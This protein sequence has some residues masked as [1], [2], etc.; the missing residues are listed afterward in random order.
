LLEKTGNGSKSQVYTARRKSDKT[1][2]AVKVQKYVTLL[3]F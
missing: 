1:I 3:L 2:F